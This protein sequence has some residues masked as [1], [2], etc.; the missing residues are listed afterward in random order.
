VINLTAAIVHVVPTDLFETMNRGK[1]HLLRG[2]EC[3]LQAVCGHFQ[4]WR[5]V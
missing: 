1:S 5:D 2:S 3:R 4:T